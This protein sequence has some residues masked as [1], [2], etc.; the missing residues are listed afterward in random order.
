MK[1]CG[2]IVAG[3]ELTLNSSKISRQGDFRY[4]QTIARIWTQQRKTWPELILYPEN[5]VDVS[6]IMQFY[7]AAHTFWGDNGFAIMGGG[8]ADFGGAQ[9]PSVIIDLHKFGETEFASSANVSA[10][11][12]STSWPILKVGGGNEAG[13][14]YSVLEGTGWAFLGPRAASIGVGGF[15]LGGGIA[16][17]TNKYGIANDNLVGLEVVLLN[18]KVIYANPYNEYSDLFWACTGAG[19]MGV[20]VITHFYIQAYPDPGVVYTVT[21]DWA[22]DQA[23]HVFEQ[24]TDFFENNQDPDAFPALLYYYKDPQEPTAI[25]PLREREFVFQLN[26][27]YFGGNETILNS[28][29]GSFYEGAAAIAIQEWT[30]KSLD[31]YLLTNYPYGYQRIFYGKSHTHSTVDFYNQTFAIYK[32]TINGLIARGEDPGHT[33]WVDEYLLP[34]LNGKLPASD[35]DTAWPHSTSAHITLTSAEWTNHTN[36]AYVYDREENHMMAYLRDFEKGLGEPA[37]YDYPNYIAPFSVASEVWGED[38]FGRLL[39]IKSKYDP[40]CLFNRGRVFATAACV[41]KG[42][43][44]TWVDKSVG[45]FIQ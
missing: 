13:D 29:F 41:D 17:Q 36:Q 10:T 16:F 9:S 33:L 2:L 27:V 1:W 34:G 37:T 35:S 32:D 31:Q 11:S 42:L 28:T 22:E 40:L 4:G 21:I 45:G 24:T 23:P 39:E 7:S 12:P 5:T 43:A 20:G 14:V 18:G 6:V 15:L 19:W 26:A 38:N 44:T 25:V 3:L 30:L 8:H